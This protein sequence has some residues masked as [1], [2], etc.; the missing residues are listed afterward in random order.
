MSE[1]LEAMKV[2]TPDAFCM[3]C[4]A[5]AIMVLADEGNV[6]RVNIYSTAMRIM[7]EHLS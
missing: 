7:Y 5:S 2:L 1:R 3:T 6:F 4:L